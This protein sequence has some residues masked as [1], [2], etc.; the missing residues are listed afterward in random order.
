MYKGTGIVRDL[1]SREKQDKEYS[2]KEA[3]QR[4]VRAAYAINEGLEQKGLSSCR[5]GTPAWAD[6]DGLQERNSQ[7]STLCLHFQYSGSASP[8][9]HFYFRARRDAKCTKWHPEN[10]SGLRNQDAFPNGL[11]FA[12]CLTVVIFRFLGSP[13]NHNWISEARCNSLSP[14]PITRCFLSCIFCLV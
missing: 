5:G 4:A 9:H 13:Y 3:K 7:L 12:K 1:A 11:V 2:P 6:H 8:V 10:Y 14:S